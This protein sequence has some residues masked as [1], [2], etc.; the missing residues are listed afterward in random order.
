MKKISFSDTNVH[1]LR[2]KFP[3]LIFLET[4]FDESVIGLST[5]MNHVIYHEIEMIHILMKEYEEDIENWDDES[6]EWCDLYDT[7]MYLVSCIEDTQCLDHNGSLCPKIF[8][9][10][11]EE[12]Q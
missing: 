5:D 1:E 10:S 11:D 4:K 8:R 9:E 6:N 2:E 3:N 7:C 12:D